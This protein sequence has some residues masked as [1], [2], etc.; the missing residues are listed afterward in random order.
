VC[1]EGLTLFQHPSTVFQH[2]STLFNA[3]QQ[4]FNTL[5]QFFNTLQQFF[6]SFSTLNVKRYLNSL[7]AVPL[8]REKR[9][10]RA[11]G[12]RVTTAVCRHKSHNSSYNSLFLLCPLILYSTYCTWYVIHLRAHLRDSI[13]YKY[14]CVRECHK[15]WRS[16]YVKQIKPGNQKPKLEHR[17]HERERPYL[18]PRHH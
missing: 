2:L 15:V 5:Q 14:R 7:L 10:G 1:G 3:A 16:I 12:H 13:I 17:R 8:K 9:Y 4:F 18:S 6:N 11:S